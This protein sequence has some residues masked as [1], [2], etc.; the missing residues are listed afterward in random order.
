MRHSGSTKPKPDKSIGGRAQKNESQEDGA[1]CLLGYDDNSNSF[2]GAVPLWHTPRT[3][4]TNLCNHPRNYDYCH[5]SD[6]FNPLKVG[7]RSLIIIFLPKNLEN[8]W[9]G[10]KFVVLK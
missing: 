8:L 3:I 5:I 2:G 7:N 1:L 9:G 10:D 4:C 6:V